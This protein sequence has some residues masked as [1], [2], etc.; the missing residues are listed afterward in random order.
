MSELLSTPT[1]LSPVPEE[2]IAT[3]RERALGDLYV[4]AKGV[5]GF[6]FLTP[7]VHMPLCRLLE[8]ALNGYTPDLYHPWS[9]YEQVLYDHAHRYMSFGE[10]DEISKE[11]LIKDWVAKVKE[12]GLG[13]LQITLPRGWLKTT[14]CS[15]AY[16]LWLGTRDTNIRV[17]LT[18][19][20]FENA[21]AKLQVIKETVEKNT[22]YRILFPEVLPDSSCRWTN[23]SLV[24]KRTK[25]WPEGTFECAGVKTAVVSRHFDLV[26]EDDTVAPDYSKLEEDNVLPSKEDIAKA[27]GWH[28][29]VPPLLVNPAKSLNFIVGTRWFEKDL[30]SWNKENHGG[31]FTFYERACLEGEDGKP[32][33]NG[34]VA[35][36]ERFSMEVLRGLKASMGPYLFSCLYMNKPIRSEDM[37]FKPDWFSYYEEEPTDLLCYTTVDLGG[38]PQETKGEPDWNVVLTCGQSTTTGV[39]YVLH[40]WRKKTNPS[41]VIDAIFKQV[42]CYHPVEVGIE[43]V[44]Y[45]RSLK[46]WIL[47]RMRAENT[48]FMVNNL[49]AAG[50]AKSYR[51]MGLQAPI[52]GGSV[53]FRIGHGPIINE[54]LSYPLG[55]HDDLA[56]CLA[57]QLDLWRPIVQMVRARKEQLG[58]DPNTLEGIKKDIRDR[59]MREA[60]REHQGAVGWGKSV[61]EHM[62]G[63]YDPLLLRV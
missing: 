26:L 25:S 8:L 13:N 38:D 18:Q 51:I 10:E 15:Q 48:H 24:L 6:D 39:V 3:L 35:Y 58:P 42:R 30:I 29:L 32:D 9:A 53:K 59:K 31:R 37:L 45:Q 44:A 23:R 14:L 16:P 43:G 50:R 41:E 17:L 4:F 27:I 34:K 46:H 22:V 47:K 62:I 5:M 33:E 54:L 11:G 49:S 1:D 19:N 20:T 60:S 2:D 36:P 12:K 52:A 7:D 56:D 57:Y 55:E 21:E 63:T 61:R 40:Y 28:K